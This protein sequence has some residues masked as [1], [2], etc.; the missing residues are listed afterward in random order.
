MKKVYISL[1]VALM[2][3]MFSFQSVDAQSRRGGNSE[4]RSRITTTQRPGRGS[5]N[6]RPSGTTRSGNKDSRPVSPGRPG[7][8][9]H[10]DNNNRP[11]SGSRPNNNS[12]RPASGSRPNNNTRPGNKT[13]SFRPGN[14]RP[15]NNGNHNG[16]RPSPTRP[17][18]KLRPAP[19]SPVTIT[20]PYSWRPERRVTIVPNIL[21]MAFGLTFNSALDYLYNSGYNVDGYGAREVYLRNVSEQGYYWN[22]ATL[23]F[24]GGGLVRSQ[25]FDSSVGY[26]TNRF[27][28]IYSRLNSEYGMPTSQSD[29]G[30]TITATW[31]GYQGD[32]I[33]LQYTLLNTSSGNRYFTILTYGN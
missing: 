30:G 1:L 12:N 16:Y 20:P 28:D 10:S 15:D 25:F 14:E 31:F 2:A 22:D 7:S 6:S 13:P 18:N 24:E 11:V 5:G 33:T 17:G 26:S 32:Y 19:S 3:G 8:S 27:Y 29:N 4:S 9:N 23:Y 21:G